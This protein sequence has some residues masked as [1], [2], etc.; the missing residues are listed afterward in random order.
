MAGYQ[1]WLDSVEIPKSQHKDPLIWY[2]NAVQEADIVAVVSAP[3]PPTAT[4]T[5]IYTGTY[6]LALELMASR[7]ASRLKSTKERDVLKHFLVLQSSSGAKR[8]EF[9]PELCSS[10]ERFLIPDQ[11]FDLVHFIDGEQASNRLFTSCLQDQLNKD[12][13]HF[14]TESFH[15]IY[16]Q[17]LAGSLESPEPFAISEQ[18]RLLIADNPT[19]N[20]KRVDDDEKLDLEFGP[21]IVKVAN[22]PSIS[23]QKETGFPP[24][25]AV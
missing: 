4:A 10:F 25:H 12:T 14:S 9:I 5:S 21:C 2:S 6:E 11:T 18:C 8:D 22:L 19:N 24:V 15:L 7:I 23:A 20:T 1:V 13:R 16:N 17:Q 3:S